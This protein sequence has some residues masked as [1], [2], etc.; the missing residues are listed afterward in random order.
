MGTV[1]SFI[2]L[3]GGVGKTT[4]AINI[5]DE[6][7]K[8]YKVLVIDMDP[9]FNATQSLLNYQI[10]HF[11]SEVPDDILSLVDKKFN[12]ENYE[13]IVDD[14]STK[15]NIKSQIIYQVLKEEKVTVNSLFIKD[16][17]VTGIISPNLTYKIK[18]NLSLI[19]GNLDLFSSLNGDSVGKHN[20]LEDHFNE[21]NLRNEFDYIIIDCPPNW[22]I[23]TQTSLFASDYYVIPSKVDL[24]SSIGIGLLEK[25]VNETYHNKSS[26]LYSTYNMFRNNQN[27]NALKPLGV[28]FTLT[29]E[30]KISN[31]IKEKLKKEII[32][33]KF[34]NS[35][36][37]Y[38]DSVA[39]K[40]SLYSEA[41]EKHIKVI[42]ALEKITTEI[43]DLIL[44]D[45]KVNYKR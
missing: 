35:E 38:Q 14:N 28:L 5:A 25:L 39:L 17:V 13:K 8:N 7:S 36:I 4:S 42:N 41:G 33:I 12:N 18:D 40:F 23:L 19:P 9:Q 11:E 3:K 45:T 26:N 31:T 24:F 15:L 27:R 1:I 44:A 43:Q 6:L 30:S 22:T 10:S 2:N 32:N 37:P 21:Y 16:S 20:I 29:N 34:L